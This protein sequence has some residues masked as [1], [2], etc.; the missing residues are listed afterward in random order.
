MLALFGTPLI[1]RIMASYAEV[2]PLADGWQQR[3]PLHQVYPLLIH[4][5]L[6]G[7]GYPGQALRAAE[8]ALAAAN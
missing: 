3:V 2:A 1:E 6:F 7:G 4:A 5:I 8:R